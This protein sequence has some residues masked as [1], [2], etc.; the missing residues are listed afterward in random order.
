MN[1]RFFAFV[2]MACSL[3]A[4]GLVGCKP[5]AT[6]AEGATTA[7]ATTPGNIVFIRLDSLTRQYTAFKEKQTILEAKA[8]EAD[9]SQ[10]ERVAIFQ[11]DVQN[12][13]RRAQSGQMAPKEIGIE[14]ERLA[15]REQGLMQEAD[16]LRQELQAEQLQLMTEYEENLRAVLDEVQKEFNYDYILSYGSGTGVLMANDQHDITPE[17]AKR[18][19]LVPMDGKVKADMKADSTAV[20]PQ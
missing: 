7:A 8:A 16:R 20:A 18:I 5:A 1:I 3:T 9:K 4:F 13:Q 10:N 15:G 14:Q 19:N 2:L 17:V 11:R 12:A 6:P